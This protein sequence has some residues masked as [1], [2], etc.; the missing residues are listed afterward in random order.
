MMVRVLGTAFN[1]KA[2]PT[3]EKIETTLLRGRVEAG[4]IELHSRPVVLVKNQQ[5][6][7]NVQTNS[8]SVRDVEAA[9]VASWK[10]GILIFDNT[11]F[12]EVKVSLERRYGV[13]ITLD[14]PRSLSCH[15]SGVV[16]DEPIAKVLD[17]LQTTSKITYELNGTDVRLKGSLCQTS[18]PDP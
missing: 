5:A 12:S 8:I 7:L 17:L 16:R 18:S 9:D 13:N 1:V 6:V 15:F 2:F 3:D 11:P 10:D 14:D 4:T